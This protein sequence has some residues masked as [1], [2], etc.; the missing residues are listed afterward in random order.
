MKVLSC[1]LSCVLVMFSTMQKDIFAEVMEFER[2]DSR[3]A[4]ARAEW[5]L[6][7]LIDSTY[8]DGDD[9]KLHNTSSS[10]ALSDSPSTTYATMDFEAGGVALNVVATN[11]TTSS[12]NLA[13]SGVFRLNWAGFLHAMCGASGSASG[14]FQLQPPVDTG[15]DTVVVTAVIELSMRGEG[16]IYPDCLI[17]GMADALGIT[18]RLQHGISSPYAKEALIYSGNVLLWS[19]EVDIDSAYSVVVEQVI[20]VTPGGTIFEISALSGAGTFFTEELSTPM[21]V[22][23]RGSASCA[24]SAIGYNTSIDPPSFS[25]LR[26]FVQKIVEDEEEQ[27][28]PV[29]VYP[30][31]VP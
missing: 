19:D 7:D 24:L 23:G 21:G 18:A 16:D 4:Q 17:Y 22:T 14:Q 15:I 13:T 27:E 30:E 20:P 3:D 11:A 9:V 2:V 8:L 1:L 29:Q 12:P 5:F 26:I 25:G 10:A 6:Y 31:L 28:P